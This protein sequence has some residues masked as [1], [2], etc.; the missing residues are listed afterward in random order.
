MRA[1]LGIITPAKKF[2]EIVTSTWAIMP[3]YTALVVAI[4]SVIVTPAIAQDKPIDWQQTAMADIEAA[5]KE[6]LENH[7]GM[8][9]NTNPKFAKLLQK[10]RAEALTLARQVTGAGGYSAAIGRF[11]S[12][13]DDGHAGAS[14]EVP[15]EL[16]PSIRW[17]GFI[18]A[19]RGNAMYVSKSSAGGP[20]EGSQ[21]K[22][23]D[24]IAIPALIRGNVFQY[25]AGQ[26]TLGNWWA[27]ARRVFV[28]DGNPFIKLPKSCIFA[29]GQKNEV[30]TLS[31][32]AIP[33]GY[34]TWKDASTNGERM[35]VG[36]TQPAP[37]MYWLAMQDFQ[38]DEKGSDA[39][40]KMFAQIEASR[41]TMRQAKAIVIDLRFNNGGSSTWPETAAKL[42]WGA[43]QFE[44]AMA[45][46]NRN[47]EI[48]WLP[49]K[50]NE[51]ALQEYRKH[52]A[53][54]G[55][56][57]IVAYF[58][59]IIEGFSNAGKN[60]KSFWIEPDDYQP[61]TAKPAITAPGDAAVLNTP[62]YVIMPGQCASACLDA[63]DYFTR[64]PNTKLI[65]APSSSDSTY[66]G[67]RSA[68]LPS[69]MGGAIIPM[70]IWR[71]RPR[72]NGVFYPPDIMM[73]DLDWSTA[74]FQKRIEADLTARKK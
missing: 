68:P 49:T 62:V 29:I 33:D 37:G 13:I 72:G 27:N 36:M 3:V 70:K 42:L 38:P 59:E 22:S 24:G 64:F 6:T 71:G 7:P 48:W 5:Y 20:P 39:Y 40:K 74:N 46:Y 23:C 25:R 54:Q 58:D 35:D 30:R 63:V 57:E 8:L 69:G 60:S 67:V 1:K 45:Y 31:W 28:D 12:V 43:P 73:N 47:V 16:S 9:D 66:M 55:N 44:R 4:F 17:A 26:K 34:Q 65:G 53:K 11:S 19:W 50:G 41:A 18:G 10:A 15:G 14:T 51:A 32:S 2:A 21:I 52:Y 61:N 56:D